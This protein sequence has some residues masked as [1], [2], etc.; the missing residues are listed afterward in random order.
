M[1]WF[2]NKYRI[3]FVCF[4]LCFSGFPAQAGTLGV[5]TYEINGSSVTITDCDTAA[6]RVVDVPGTIEGKPVTSI[7]NN[8]FRYCNLLMGVMLPE[9]IISIGERAFERCSSLTTITLPSGVTSIGDY[10][11]YS[12]SSLSSITMPESVTTIGL[13]AFAN[14]G[15]LSHITIPAGITSIGWQAFTKCNGLL[16][17]DVEAGNLHY[18]SNDG[19]LFN[20]TQTTLIKYPAMKPEAAYSIPASVTRIDYGA[21][22]YS[23]SLTEITLPTSLTYIDYNAFDSCSSLMGITIPAAVTT[24]RDRIFRGCSS[25]ESIIVEAGNLNYISLD[26]VL[27]NADQTVIM[28]YP[29]LKPDLSYTIPPTV[30]DIN[31]SAFEDCSSLESITI[32]Y[33]V[34]RVEQYTFYNCSSLESITIP[35]GV[36]TI[37]YHAFDNCRSLTDIALPA[38]LAKIYN[39]AFEDCSSLTNITI[40]ASVTTIGNVFGDCSSLSSIVVEEGSLHYRSINGVLFNAAETELIVYPAGRPDLSYVV[41]DSVTSLA[42]LALGD[43]L[44]LT[45]LTLPSGLNSI[46]SVAFSGCR[47]LTGLTIPASVTSIGW[48]PFFDCEALT[49]VDVEIGNSNYYSSNGVLFDIDQTELIAYPAGKTNVSYIVPASV[50]TIALNAFR[51]S[52]QLLSILVE[53]GNADFSSIDGVLFNADQTTL[54]IYPEG[55]AGTYNIPAGVTAI[56]D[57]GFYGCSLLTGITMPDSL[58]DIGYWGFEWCPL[59]TEISLPDSVTRLGGGAFYRCSGL[60]SITIPA[61]VDKIENQTFWDCSGLSDVHFLGNAPALGDEVFLGTDPDLIIHYL[62]TNSGYATPVWKGFPATSWFMDYGVHPDADLAEDPNG[63]GVDLLTAYALNLDPDLDLSGSLPGAEIGNDAMSMTYYAVSPGV[64]YTVETCE[65]L[66]TWMTNGV[67]VSGLDP[68][69]QRTGAVDLTD[70]HRFLR[71][72]VSN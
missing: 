12:C 9:G 47:S 37:Y 64:T 38:G 57:R 66:E 44:A 24:I 30:T 16:S 59:L 43:S 56:A 48:Q 36:S 23:G 29:P 10:G 71:L 11:F 18:V 32:P 46:G 54:V 13:S 33:G 20:A 34:S 19:I 49:F 40:P 8:A 51:N 65:D 62:S 55:R 42:N 58:T 35:I 28:R 50:D 1:K 17:I 4:H 3:L 45:N 15:S 27:F 25:L 63:D 70:P 6:D 69:N 61:G 26:G 5:L 22:A 31:E 41:P 2:S 52:N 7:G 39:G 53:P 67:S 68:A 60:S 72:Q 21:L 14:C